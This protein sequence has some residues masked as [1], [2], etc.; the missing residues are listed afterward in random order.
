MYLLFGLFLL[1]CILFLLL[2]FWKRRRIICKICA[3]D[4]CEK[5]C[6]L[7]EILEPFGFC[8]LVDQDAVTSRVDA[9]Q[10]EF[11]YCSLFDKSAVHFQMVFDCEPIYFCHDGKTWMIEFWKGQYGITAGA[12]I[13]V[14]RADGI[15]APEQYEH[16]LFQSVSD[17]DLFP[18][19]MELFFKGSSL[20]TIR[21]C[22][23]WLTGFRPGV[24][25]HPEDLV[26]NIS[27]TFPNQTML[28]SFTDGLMQTGYRSCDLCVCG[29]TVSFTFASPRTRQPRLD[30]RLSQWFSQ[31]K[32]RMF[33]ALYRWITRPFICTSD[34]VLYLYY[35]LPYAFRHMFTM[36]RNG[37]QRL[38]RKRRKNK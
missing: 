1:L 37:K 16:A 30:C 11:G 19:S 8:Y 12:E 17:E 23:W 27:V 21:R 20:F 18:M 3:M 35:F 26:L 32:N 36:R 10:R 15:L 28:R 4:S 9:W 38:R 5:A 13:G 24:W 31:W 7:N 33:C 2:N 22:H 14:Y 34:R 6:L 25:V 29:L